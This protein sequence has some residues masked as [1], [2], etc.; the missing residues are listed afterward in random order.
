MEKFFTHLIALTL[1]TTPFILQAQNTY[2]DNVETQVANGLE[3]M[4]LKQALHDL[5]DE[6][7]ERSYTGVL[8]EFMCTYDVDVN[9]TIIDRYKNTSESCSGNSLPGSFIHREHVMP[10]SWWGG[11]TSVTHYKDFH[12]LFPADAGTNISK[13][14]HPL[15]IVGGSTGSYPYTVF[16]MTD[17]G[18]DGVSCTDVDPTTSSDDKVFEPDDGYKGDFARVFLYMSVRYQDEIITENWK[19]INTCLLYTSPSPRD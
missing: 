13:S 10:K 17:I 7:T 1:F 8:P 18:L 3:C 15:G 14:A 12:N 5:I 4:P 11:S 19:A 9:G 2:Y 6:H 16:P